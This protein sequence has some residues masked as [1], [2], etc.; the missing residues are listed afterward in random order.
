[1]TP[2]ILSSSPAALFGEKLAD[3]AA[4]TSPPAKPARKKKQPG[5][6]LLATGLAGAGALSTGL[7][8][9][10]ASDQHAANIAKAISRHGTPLDPN[11]TNL[12]RYTELLSHGANSKPMGMGIGNILATA[13]S[14]PT[15]MKA[16]G[17]DPNYAASKPGSFVDAEAH[18]DQFRKGPIAAYAHMMHPNKMM[19][20]G[21]YSVDGKSYPDY[22]KP[23]F[24]QAWRKFIDPEKGIP[25]MRGNANWVE[26]HE[27]DTNK[28]PYDKQVQ[29]LRDYHANLPPEVRA[30]KERAENDMTAGGTAPALEKNLKNYL[31]VADNALK[32]RQGLKDVGVAGLGAGAGGALGHYLARNSKKKNPLAYW[33]SVLGGTGLGGAAS[34]LGG[35]DSGRQRLA[36]IIQRLRPQ[37]A[38]T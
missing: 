33:A 21:E 1:M 17:V 7:A 27:I 38:L 14:S 16:M 25:E 35:T 37:T 28:I 26:P 22:M 11:E 23:H 30:I 29:F 2:R 32:V 12:S 8:Y 6:P 34:Y 20:R 3:L 15:L 9:G 5:M 13:R 36:Q 19:N 10:M 31:P 24:D 4:G 18:Y